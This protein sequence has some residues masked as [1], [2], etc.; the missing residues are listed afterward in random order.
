M[1]VQFDPLA[2]YN[3]DPG[4]DGAQDFELTTGRVIYDSYSISTLNKLPVSI[5]HAFTTAGVSW[6][7]QLP[8]QL[9]PIVEAVLVDGSVVIIDNQ[10]LDAQ[11]S[12]FKKISPDRSLL[13]RTVAVADDQAI[14]Y[15]TKRSEG[16]AQI[17]RVYIR[18]AS[19]WMMT[20]YTNYG[21][22]KEEKLDEI[23]T[24]P[25]D[26]F[27]VYPNGTGII[28]P[29]QKTYMRLEEMED[30]L[31]NQTTDSALTVIIG[32]NTGG[33]DEA[34]KAQR[35]GHR[36]LFFPDKDISVNRVADTHI[37]DQLLAQQDSLLRRYFM[38]LHIV[39]VEANANM[40]GVARRLSMLPT[41]NFVDTVRDDVEM[42]MDDLGYTG[43]ISWINL[44]LTESDESLKRVELVKMV[45]AEINMTAEEF[46]RHL[47]ELL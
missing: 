36:L 13:F 34:I 24:M 17:V 25:F 9:N 30:T 21:T 22:D 3:F 45:K 4:G 2:E 38:A 40:S 14:Q 35:L 18:S 20:D 32:G 11:H 28:E 26:S 15:L 29:Y 5:L 7:G 33:R 37:T 6:D 31:R 41:L 19:A 1:P 16:D 43:K 23:G 12:E 47:R 8:V 44:V 27:Y 42:I 39:D 46:N 10:Y